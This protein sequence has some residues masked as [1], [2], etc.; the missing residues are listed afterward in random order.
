MHTRR[1]CEATLA[2][3][4]PA[5]QAHL[6]RAQSHLTGG[7][8]TILFGAAD[9]ILPNAKATF[10]TALHHGTQMNRCDRSSRGTKAKQ[11]FQ[12]HSRAKRLGEEAAWARQMR[13]TRQQQYYSRTLQRRGVGWSAHLQ[14]RCVRRPSTRRHCTQSCCWHRHYCYQH[15]Q[16][17]AGSAA[18]WRCPRHRWKPW[19]GSNGTRRAPLWYVACLA[20]DQAPAECTAS[21]QT[22][23]IDESLSLGTSCRRDVYKKNPQLAAARAAAGC[24]ATSPH[25]CRQQQAAR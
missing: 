11:A 6:P 8:I 2:N 3:P 12:Q 9:E 22:A 25:S 17:A 14:Q 7:L 21:A 16:T 18:P 5:T 10:C 24:P 19:P 13:R 1:G 23:S 15:V 20:G 4:L